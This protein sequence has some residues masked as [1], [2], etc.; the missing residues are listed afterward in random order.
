VGHRSVG[1]PCDHSARWRQSNRCACPA[2]HWHSRAEL[3]PTSRHCRRMKW[4]RAHSPCSS[5]QSANTSCGTSLSGSSQHA[6]KKRDVP[7]VAKGVQKQG[8]QQQGHWHELQL[9]QV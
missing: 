6:C 9:A 5:S 3:S 4:A 8:T 7:A 2:A 1:I